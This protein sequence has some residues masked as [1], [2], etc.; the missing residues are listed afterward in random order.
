MTVASARRPTRRM[1][2]AIQPNPPNGGCMSDGYIANVLP[3][4]TSNALQEDTVVCMLEFIS[5]KNW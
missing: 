1:A 5:I 4:L 3:L 2:H